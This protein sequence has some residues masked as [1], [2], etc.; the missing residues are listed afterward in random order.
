MVREVGDEHAGGCHSWTRRELGDCPEWNRLFGV[1]VAA[2]YELLSVEMGYLADQAQS[3]AE[4]GWAFQH[5]AAV[6]RKY[7]AKRD[8]IAHMQSHI[9]C[10]EKPFAA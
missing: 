6:V 2:I 10:A 7:H 5:R 3:G 4:F 8:L 1:F 9:S